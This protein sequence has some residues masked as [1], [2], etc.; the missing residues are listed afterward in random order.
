MRLLTAA[1]KIQR[2]YLRYDIKQESQA[3][4]HFYLLLYT[5]REDIGGL[6]AP[7]NAV[8]GSSKTRPSNSRSSL[9][10]VCCVKAIAIK[11]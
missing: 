2:L 6:H 4:V 3:S 9:D 8:S 7:G 11:T 1:V 10:I 5:I